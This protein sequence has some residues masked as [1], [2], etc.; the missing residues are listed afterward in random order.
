[1][2]R[3]KAEKELGT[4][5]SSIRIASMMFS[6]LCMQDMFWASERFLGAIYLLLFVIHET[7]TV[8]HAYTVEVTKTE[9]K[10]YEGDKKRFKMSF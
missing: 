9:I 8:E 2:E 7:G 10:M 6:V 5:G 4:L 3:H 1:M